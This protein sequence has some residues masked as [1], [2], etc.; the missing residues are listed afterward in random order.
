[1]HMA[2]QSGRVGQLAFDEFGRPFIIFKD[3]EKKKRLTGLAAHK[4]HILAAKSVANT[5]RTSLGPKGLDKLLV[6]PDGDITVTNDGRTILDKMDVEHEIAKLLV[7]LSRSQDDEV[8]DGTTGVVVLAGALLDQAEQLLDRGIHP[9]RIADG[10]ELAAKRCLAILDE[11][12][13]HFDF[14]PLN[15]EP[16]IKTAMTA[17][18]SKIVNRC[19]R[20]FAEIA[21]EA[22]LTVADFERQDVDFELIKV[23]GKV[24][25]RLED[26]LIV[27]GVII[28]KDFSHPQMPRAVENARLAIL[29]CPFEPPKPKTK[30][31][32]YVSSVDDY[33]KLK[34]YEQGK[35]KEMVQM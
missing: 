30:H 16:L 10:Y 13:D 25:G 33:N 35:F 15:R 5:L 7:Q 8:G 11:I 23:E 24:G 6:S 19:Q 34:E 3:Q 18:G 26:S 9:I 2:M 14:S 22:V 17:L 28:D 4:S 12:S 32:L 29:T 27:K 21:V 1:M 20:Q 31:N